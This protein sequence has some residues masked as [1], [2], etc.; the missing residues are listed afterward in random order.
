MAKLHHPNIAKSRPYLLPIFYEKYDYFLSYFGCFLLKKGAWSHVKKFES[1]F[2]L[3][4]CSLT[5]LEH[6][7]V[8]FL[9]PAISNF[10]FTRN[11]GRFFLIWTHFH[12]FGCF[13]RCQTHSSEKNEFQVLVQNLILNRL[14]QFL[15]AKYERQKSSCGIFFLP[16]FV[17]GPF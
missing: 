3:P 10:E 1:K 9:V 17:F 7:S 4:Y 12:K 6:I 14:A 11:K 8:I 5:I 15:N 2:D 13:S 16:C